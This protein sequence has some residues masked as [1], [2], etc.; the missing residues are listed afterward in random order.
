MA[1]PAFVLPTLLGGAL[2]GGASNNNSNSNSNALNNNSTSPV[3]VSFGGPAFS[4][5]GSGGI[6]A[7]N[8]AQAHSV[9]SSQASP[10]SFGLPSLPSASGLIEPN[11]HSGGGLFSNPYLWGVAAFV[12]IYLY[13]KRG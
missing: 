5:P 3:T 8:T 10:L 2:G 1:L 9:P 11:G 12:G 6:T 13:S 7:T 4:Y